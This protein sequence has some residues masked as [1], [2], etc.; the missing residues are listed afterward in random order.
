MTTGRVAVYQGQPGGV[1]WFKPQK[2]SDTNYKVS[3]LHP[4]TSTPL[5]QTI[6]EPTLTDALDV[7]DEPLCRPAQCEASTTPSTTTTSTTTTTLKK[8]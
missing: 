4:S 5:A 7:R 3:T 2:V 6:P 8:G 1:L